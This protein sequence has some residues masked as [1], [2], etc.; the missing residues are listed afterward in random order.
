VILVDIPSPYLTNIVYRPSKGTYNR[1]TGLWTGFTLKK[2]QSIVLTVT[3]KVSPKA[4]G[5][6]TNAVLLS[7]PVKP[8]GPVDPILINNV[9][10]ALV[11]IA[12]PPVSKRLFLTSR[13]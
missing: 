5:T 9:A 4:T 3:G 11:A 12:P 10:S 6:L 2:G 8:G 13:R 7:L 1:T